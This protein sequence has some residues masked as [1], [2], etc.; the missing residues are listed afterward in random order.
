MRF[1]VCGSHKLLHTNFRQTWCQ[2]ILTGRPQLILQCLG[3]KFDCK[4]AKITSISGTRTRIPRCVVGHRLWWRIKKISTILVS[5]NACKQTEKR[6][7]P[8]QPDW[9]CSLVFSVQQFSFNFFR[10]EKNQWMSKTNFV[11]CTQRSTWS[12]R[13]VH[14]VRQN[15]WLCRSQRAIH[16]KR[17]ID[18]RPT[19]AAIGQ[20]WH[21]GAELSSGKHWKQRSSAAYG[22]L[23]R[24]D[25][26]IAV[27]LSFVCELSFSTDSFSG[28]QYSN[29]VFCG[30]FYSLLSVEVGIH[31][32][33]KESEKL[34]KTYIRL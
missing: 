6:L 3:R 33:L 30:G 24:D 8:F 16:H 2:V 11:R 15:S 13:S 22:K 32:A 7:L 20:A 19:R 9:T 23:L 1:C 31:V 26:S 12:S 21:C 28:E 4:K 10:R 27:K 14:A 18:F 29:K 5:S 34:L 25:R 17:Q